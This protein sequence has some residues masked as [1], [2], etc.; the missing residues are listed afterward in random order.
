MIGLFEVLLFAT[1]FAAYLAWRLLAPVLPKVSLWAAVTA[2]LMV[3]MAGAWTASRPHMGA[4]QHYAP[5]TLRN[6]EILPGHALP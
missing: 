5:A 4:G 2:V 3:G 6:G 1:P